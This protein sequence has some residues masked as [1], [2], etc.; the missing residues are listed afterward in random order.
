MLDSE[1]WLILGTV[2][3]AILAILYIFD[4]VKKKDMEE[5]LRWLDGFSATQQI[6]SLNGNSGIAIDERSKKVCLI[7]RTKGN[8]KLD[9]VSYS[10]I[11]SSEIFEDGKT[12]TKTSRSSQLGGTILGGLALGGVGAII[13]GLSGDTTSSKKVEHIQLRIVVNRPS[14]P[15]HDITIYYGVMEMI[16]GYDAAMRKARHWHGL[17]EI[18]IKQADAEDTAQREHLITENT[19]ANPQMSVADELRKLSELQKQGLLTSE[20]FSAQ[21]EKLLS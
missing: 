11:L 9:V 6:M 17:L 14:N 3:S 20:E 15:I 4:L 10:D 1:S 5:K 12:I 16:S 2:G 8:F 21:K 19:T 7:Q 13:G 18:I